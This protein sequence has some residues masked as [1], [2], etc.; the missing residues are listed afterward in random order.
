MSQNPSQSQTDEKPKWRLGDVCIQ[1]VWWPKELVTEQSLNAVKNFEVRDDDVWVATWPKAGT[2]WVAEICHLIH[3][4]G[5]LDAVDR[6][7]QPMPMEFEAHRNENKVPRYKA[8]PSWESPR[9]LVTHVPKRFLPD[10]LLQGKGKVIVVIRNLKDSQVSYFHFTKGMFPGSQLTFEESLHANLFSDKVQFSP[11]FDHV[12][13]YLT[14]RH[15]KQYLF[16]KYED[17][18][19]DTRGAVIQVA[20]FLGR[21]LSDEVIDKIVDLVTVKSMK[22]RY[23]VA[24]EES[25]PGRGVEG[26]IGATSL[27]RKGTHWVA[28][29]CHLVHHDGNLDAVDRAQQPMPIEFEAFRSENK[30]PRYKAAP[31]WESPRVLVTHAPKRFLPDQLLQGKG[32]V[33]VVIRNLKDSQV[34]YFHFTKGMRPGSQLTFEESLHTN[35]FSDKVQFSPWFDHVAEYLTERHNKQYLFLKYEDMKADTRGAV[36]QVADFLG[37]PL[38]DEVIDK[39]VDLVTVKSMKTR[40]HVAG[41]VSS[42]PGRTVEG[43]IGAANLL[44]KGVVGDWKNTFTVAQS[45]AFDEF[46]L[47][48]MADLGLKL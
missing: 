2:H 34:S 26:K 31:S 43:K 32:K 37:R 16:L 9:V 11:W 1:G 6:A 4:D 19:A 38:S 48:K 28:E 18:K 13:E 30:V 45:E 3:H 39:I 7:Q 29:I 36:I 40:Y 23:H 41:E 8:A 27:M 24:G 35:L 44:R 46:Y 42:S 33:I 17:M 21:P 5:D 47:Q 25:S 20:D 14:E 22:T 15:N 10:Q 12:A